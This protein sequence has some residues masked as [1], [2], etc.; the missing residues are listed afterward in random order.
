MPW[1]SAKPNNSTIAHSTSSRLGSAGCRILF[2]ASLT[3]LS[4]ILETIIRIRRFCR[5]DLSLSVQNCT[6]LVR[7]ALQLTPGFRR[8]AVIKGCY[9]QSSV[10]WRIGRSVSKSRVEPCSFDPQEFRLRRCRQPQLNNPTMQN[11]ST[12]TIRTARIARNCVPAQG[13]MQA[14]VAL[15]VD[16]LQQREEH[17][18]IVDLVGN[19]GHIPTV[20]VPDWVRA[21]LDEWFAAAAID[22]GRLFRPVNKVGRTW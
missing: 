18:A 8:L 20:P 22:R 9:K 4:M 6:P 7:R 15:T 3:N 21:E 5:D 11:L 1:R 13:Q 17:W 10:F 14:A 12:A 16:H 19:G 2:I